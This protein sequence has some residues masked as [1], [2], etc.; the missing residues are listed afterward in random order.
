MYV[1][2]PHIGLSSTREVFFLSLSL[3]LSRPF[4]VS[5]LQQQQQLKPEQN[6]FIE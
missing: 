4:R 1:R 5:W 3:A 6:N 2:S